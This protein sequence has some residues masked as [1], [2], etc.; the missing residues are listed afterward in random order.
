[1]INNNKKISGIM[2]LYNCSEI[3]AIIRLDM[4]EQGFQ[5]GKKEGQS[6]AQRFF[7]LSLGIEKP[8]FSEKAYWNNPV[9]LLDCE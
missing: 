3:D 7:R 6:E 1:M 8:S 9:P 5:A 4:Y 2:S